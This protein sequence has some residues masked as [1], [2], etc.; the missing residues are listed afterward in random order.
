MIPL[1]VVEI[2]E[3]NEL[4]DEVI[5]KFNGWDDPFREQFLKRIYWYI[6]CRWHTKGREEVEIHGSINGIGPRHKGGPIL[7]HHRWPSWVP[8]KPADW[9]T[10]E[11]YE[12]PV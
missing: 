2:S 6:L 7:A 5:S 9:D 3:A 12:S 1:K 8:G 11:R 4:F 10:S